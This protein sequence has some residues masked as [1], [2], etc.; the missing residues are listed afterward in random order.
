MT[1]LATILN[2]DDTERMFAT[3]TTRVLYTREKTKCVMWTNKFEGNQISLIIIKETNFYMLNY[4]RVVW[5]DLF[6]N[7]FILRL[8]LKPSVLS[9]N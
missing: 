2:G 9:D 5:L 3:F 8:T 6:G 7:R 4:A 1:R